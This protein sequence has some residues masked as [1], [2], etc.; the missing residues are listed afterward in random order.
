MKTF[1]VLIFASVL[2]GCVS[3]PESPD[4]GAAQLTAPQS[5]VDV[6]QDYFRIFAKRQDFERFMGFYAEQAELQDMVYGKHAVGAEQIYDFYN[7]NKGEFTLIKPEALVVTQQLVK[8]KV[9]VTRGYFTEF[10]YYGQKAGPWRFVIWQ[11]FNQSNQIILQYD[12]INYTPKE[13][14]IGG[15]NMNLLIET[16]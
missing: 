14:Y 1:L 2:A 5:L 13:T 16:P 7:W 6:A 3:V 15:D 12:W 8:D 10:E 11:E 9:V 4:S